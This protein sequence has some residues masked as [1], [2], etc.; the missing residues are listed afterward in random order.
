M[1]VLLA[2]DQAA[3]EPLE[4]ILR[5]RGLDLSTHEAGES[6]AGALVSLERAIE[7]E[8]PRLAVAVG[9]GEAA[10]AL[11]I[12]APKL[13]IPFLAW[14][15]PTETPERADQQRVLKTLSSA[16]SQPLAGDAAAAA[17]EIA[18]WLTDE[19]PEPDLDSAL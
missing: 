16:G 9:M 2:G 18:A 15:G 4:A 8:E 10:L 5:E 12:T 14:L 11:A 7:A 6:I 3:A 13:G 1:D 19:P 17:N